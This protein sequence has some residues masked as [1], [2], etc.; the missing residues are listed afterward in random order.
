VTEFTP[1]TE[2]D[3]RNSSLEALISL[4]TDPRNQPFAVE[5]YLKEILGL[6]NKIGMSPYKRHNVVTTTPD[7]DE[8]RFK[9]PKAEADFVIQANLGKRR[10]L[11]KGNVPFPADNR[12]R[13]PL[14]GDEGYES[15]MVKL[16]KEL[17]SKW[18]TKIVT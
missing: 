17:E 13:C 4:K 18:K 2:F 12:F 7:Y 10:R 14:C 3:G 6:E 5:K 1:L 11:R 9:C 16:R 8:L 15:Q